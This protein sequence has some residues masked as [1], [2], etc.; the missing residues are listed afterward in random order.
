MELVK[1][2][3]QYNFQHWN[4]RSEEHSIAASMLNTIQVRQQDYPLQILHSVMSA[5]KKSEDFSLSHQM[6]FQIMKFTRRKS[7]PKISNYQFQKSQQ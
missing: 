5:L 6:D 1:N 7:N 3:F 4:I 2:F